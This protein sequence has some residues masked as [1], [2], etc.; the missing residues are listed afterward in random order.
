MKF[1]VFLERVFWAFFI[2]FI[3]L[4]LIGVAWAI[5]DSAKEDMQK[6][7][8]CEDN[9]GVT[10]GSGFRGYK[11]INESGIYEVVKLNEEWK[12]IK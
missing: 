8:I 9:N 11:C 7:D 10:K 6:R 12:M 3:I 5:L 4:G 1:K 2:G